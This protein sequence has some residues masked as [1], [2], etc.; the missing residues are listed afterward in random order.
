MEEHSAL[1][2]EA[3]KRSN[4][5]GLIHGTHFGGLSNGYQSRLDVVLITDAV[6]SAAD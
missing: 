5:N 1:M 2:C 6:I 3:G 4:L